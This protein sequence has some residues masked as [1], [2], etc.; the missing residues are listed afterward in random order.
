MDKYNIDQQVI[1]QSVMDQY[2]K[3]TSQIHAP[4]DL[5]RRTKEAVRA[6]EQRIAREKQQQ[7]AVVQPKHSYGKV[8]KWALPVAAAAVCVILLNVSG[9]LFGRSKGGS[10]SGSSMDMAMETAPS[11]D[12][13]MGIQAGAADT[14]G[15]IAEAAQ[16]PVNKGSSNVNTAVTMEDAVAAADEE[17]ENEDYDGGQSAGAAVSSEAENDMYDT[18]ES[19]EA[20]NSY[21]KSIYGSDLWLEEVDKVPSFYTD[22]DTECIIIH[23]VELYVAQEL[24]DTWIAYV[25]IDEQKYV[26]CGELTEEDISREEFADEAY[27]LL[28]DMVEF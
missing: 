6:E 9:L 21:I 17:Y 12:S 2:H 25:E 5:I 23:G 19:V 13:S 20:E 22:T 11:N 3:E 14:A 18:A 15:E 26:V 16:E 28:E 8:Y 4:A 10:W 27:K 7:N 24:D 1:E